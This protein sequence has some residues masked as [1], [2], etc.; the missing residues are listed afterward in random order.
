M[1]GRSTL[2]SGS[3]LLGRFLMRVTSNYRKFTRRKIPLIC[4]SRLFWEWSLHIAKSYSIS[5]QLLELGGARL[6]ELRVA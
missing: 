6:D 5:F 2:T 3:T 4:L 1:Q